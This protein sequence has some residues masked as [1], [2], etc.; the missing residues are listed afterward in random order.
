MQQ[1]IEEI[2]NIIRKYDHAYYGLA[3]PIVPDAEY[4]RLM[5]RLVALE[6]FFRSKFSNK[7]IQ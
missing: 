3:Q 2:R 6:P 4:D 1:E 5:R 7:K